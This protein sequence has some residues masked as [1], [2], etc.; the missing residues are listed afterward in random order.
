[1]EAVDLESNRIDF[2]GLNL[3][4]YIKLTELYKTTK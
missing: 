2:F 3:L 4:H 1:M